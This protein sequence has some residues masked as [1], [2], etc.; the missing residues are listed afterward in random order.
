MKDE[1]V[2]PETA[3]AATAAGFNWNTSAVLL[4]PP[5]QCLLARWL[6]ETHGVHID[7]T[8][9]IDGEGTLY[10]HYFSFDL[11]RSYEAA[12]EAGLAHALTRIN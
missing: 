10:T 6:R 5:T 3:K 9:V 1:L 8:H 7:V 11:F 4:S 2:S 12:M